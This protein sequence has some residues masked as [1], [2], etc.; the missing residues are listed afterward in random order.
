L[1]PLQ[2]F[3][4]YAGEDAFE[5]LLL[6]EALER[7]LSDLSVRVWAYGRDQDADQRSIGRSIK[8]RVQESAA[9]VVL[10]SRFTLE[11]GATQ[12]MELAYADAFDIPAFVLLHHLS[13]DELRRSERGAP[14]LV[15]EGQCTLAIHWRTLE[16]GLRDACS[17]DNKTL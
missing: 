7:L 4:S 11:S 6:K 12:W 9:V 1:K 14:P 16:N 17:K 15:L 2:V 13:F 8:D 3:L 10:V 5:A